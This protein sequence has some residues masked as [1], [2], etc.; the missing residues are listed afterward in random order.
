MIVGGR[1]PDGT[2]RTGA[3]RHD[4]CC[5]QN[6]RICMSSSA[7]FDGAVCARTVHRACCSEARVDH[8]T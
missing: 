1:I 3:H 7:T 6:T 2:A 8:A 4:L 5:A